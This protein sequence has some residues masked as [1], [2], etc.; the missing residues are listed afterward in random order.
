MSETAEPLSGSSS[1]HLVGPSESLASIAIRYDSTPSKLAQL[2]KL[3]SHMVY[4]GQK[5]KVPSH[6][7]LSELFPPNKPAPSPSLPIAKCQTVRP[8]SQ[9]SSY[10]N[11][12]LR[13]TPEHKLASPGEEFS[14]ALMRIR[15]KYITQ[16]RGCVLGRLHLTPQAIIFVPDSGD[17]L[18]EDRGRSE[19]AVIV[20]MHSISDL[21]VTSYFTKFQVSERT[22]SPLPVPSAKPRRETPARSSPREIGMFP[23]EIGMSPGE[24]ELGELPEISFTKSRVETPT[25]EP[26][27]KDS[28]LLSDSDDSDPPGDLLQPVFLRFSVLETP[29]DTIDALKASIFSRLIRP[30]QEADSAKRAK[31]RQEYWF[32]IPQA[33]SDSLYAFVLQYNSQI[34]RPGPDQLDASCLQFKEDYI[35]TDAS[36][37]SW[38][39]LPSLDT[40]REQDHR[41]AVDAVPLPSLVGTASLL[42]RPLLRELNYLLPSRTVGHDLWLVYSSFV[43]GISLRTMYRNMEACSGPVVFVL[44]DDRQQLFGGVVSCPLRVSDHYYGTGESFM[45]RVDASPCKVSP[46]RWTGL[47]TFFVKGDHDS[48]SFGGGNGKPALWIDGDF[49]N[50]SSFPCLT[51]DNLQLSGTEDFLCTGFEAW[52]FVDWN[53]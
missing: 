41:A 8:S 32:A 10:E 45:F 28:A 20:S 15:A 48:I 9:F 51:F 42:S 4:P 46:Y 11:L 6:E 52:G 16:C 49:Y 3:S 29:L 19:F 30:Y 22:S 37:A 36:S 1:Q 13:E 50:G 25:P 23:R 38:D 31:N 7:T 47:N 34:P 27:L 2:N 43:H 33:H 26:R 18:V 12:S 53:S 5:L 21:T 14:P 35:E 24:F 17:Q 40:L 44:R 39:V